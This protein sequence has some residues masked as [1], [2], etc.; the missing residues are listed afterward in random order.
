MNPDGS[1]EI[2]HDILYRTTQD[3]QGHPFYVPRL[4]AFDLKGGYGSQ[5]TQE[6]I[7]EARASSAWQGQTS[8]YGDELPSQNEYMREV[9]ELR[10]Q[11]YNAPFPAEKRRN[12]G[13]E[14]VVNTWTD[15]LKQEFHPRSYCGINSHKSGIDA[16]DVYTEGYEAFKQEEKYE[17]NLD[18]IRFFLEDC[19]SVQGLHVLCTQDTGFAGFCEKALDLIREDF[20]TIPIFLYGTTPVRVF[21]YGES[22]VQW[23]E[24]KCQLNTAMASYYYSELATVYC[25]LTF[26]QRRAFPGIDVCNYYQTS[27]YLSALIDN[28]SVHYRYTSR[29]A[30]MMQTANELAFRPSN[31]F[32]AASMSLNIPENSTKEFADL[33]NKTTDFTTA[34]FLHQYTNAPSKAAHVFS[35]AHHVRGLELS[36]SDA[37]FVRDLVA[38]QRSKSRAHRFSTSVTNLPFCIPSSFPSTRDFA[39]RMGSAAYTH[40]RVSDDMRDL[41][42]KQASVLK[43]TATNPFYRQLQ[44]TYQ[45][46]GEELREMENRILTISDS[47]ANQYED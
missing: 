18:Q 9:L 38:D 26:S 44:N 47:Y 34:Q 23:E 35:E 22:L 33:L 39:D 30:D 40:M 2:N 43:E 13:L 37:S 46:S 41:L 8:Q 16:F 45:M 10:H 1:T 11:S 19:D 27:A 32:V 24:L 7:Q 25:P 36:P 20:P 28:A 31:R 42:D 17:D 4:V 15:F 6:E 14:S 21:D 29:P 12:Y 3:F 5:L